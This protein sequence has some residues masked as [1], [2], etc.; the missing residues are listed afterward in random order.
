[1]KSHVLR[2]V[3]GALTIALLVVAC[4]P[5]V[6][7][8]PEQQTPEP[9]PEQPELGPESEPEPEPNSATGRLTITST[10]SGA[11]ITLDGKAVVG[12]GANRSGL[13]AAT[14]AFRTPAMLDVS[15]GYHTITLQMP[16]R[17]MAESSLFV[18]DQTVTSASVSLH[19]ATALAVH[20]EWMPPLQLDRTA[21]EAR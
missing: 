10:P 9:V 15:P 6:I 8:T 19:R 12:S 2:I 21:D 1:M 7:S 20:W 13:A 17:V 3:L 18:F 5:A 16:G 11:Y 14:G 4:E